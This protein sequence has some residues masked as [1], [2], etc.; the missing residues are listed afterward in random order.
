[1]TRIPTVRTLAE[2]SNTS[3]ANALTIGAKPRA[4]AER[5]PAKEPIHR[6]GRVQAR[7]KLGPYDLGRVTFKV[8]M[9][10]LLSIRNRVKLLRSESGDSCAAQIDTD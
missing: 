9:A 8:T 7:R 1:M 2:T 5:I 6:F 4:V 10:V 3:M